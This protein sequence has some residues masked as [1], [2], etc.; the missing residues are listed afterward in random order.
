MR[1]PFYFF[2]AT[3]AR[4]SWGLFLAFLGFA[5]ALTI[6]AQD[7]PY[8]ATVKQ[9]SSAQSHWSFL[10][11]PTLPSDRDVPAAALAAKIDA[12]IDA[13]LDSLDI[14]PNPPASKTAV[15]R[16][17]SFDLTGLPPSDAARASFLG[18]DS[19]DA[20]ERLVDRLLASP[21]FGEHFGRHW[22]DLVRYADTHGLHFDNHRE[23]WMYRDYVIDSF[24]RNKRF[25]VFVIEQLAGDLLQADEP[26]L[27]QEQQIATGFLRMNLTTNEAGS[28]Y[29]EVVAKNLLDLTDAF[30]TVFLGLTTQCAQCHDHKSDPLT[31]RDYYSLAAFFN[32]FDGNAMDNNEKAPPPSIAVPSAE[33]AK[34]MQAWQERISSIDEEIRQPNESIDAAQRAWESRLANDLNALPTKS[35]IEM[36]PWHV[37]GPFDAE[38]I[39]YAY[40]KTFAS[41]GD[42][43]A[44][45]QRFF[46]RDAQL[47]WTPLELSLDGTAAELPGLANRQ[48]VSV[49]HTKIVADKATDIVL[50]LAVEDGVQVFLNDQTVFDQRGIE[51]PFLRFANITLPL[52]EGENTLYLKVVSHAA[53]SRVRIAIAQTWAVPEQLREILA[54]SPEARAEWEVDHLRSYFRGVWG[55]HPDWLAMR[56]ERNGTVRQF[57][58]LLQS[59]PRTLV[60]RESPG[61]AEQRVFQGGRYDQLGDAV[62]P[63]TPAFLP[64]IEHADTPFEQEHAKPFP[65]RLDL[66]QWVTSPENPLTAR[67]AAN[68]FWQALFGLGIVETSEDLGTEGLPP[69]H[70]DLLDLLAAEFASDWDVKRL[71]KAM[72]LSRAYRRDATFSPESRKAD[73]TNRLLARGPRNRLDA[74]QLRDQALTLAGLLNLTAGGLSSKPPQPAGIWESVGHS[75]SNTVTF[76]PDQGDAALRRSV[77][78]FWKRTSPPPSLAV[79]DA[80]TRETCV[81][82]RERTNTPAQALVTMNDPQFF[83]AA[84]RL[85]DMTLA[86]DANEDTNDGVNDGAARMEWLFDRVVGRAMTPRESEELVRLLGDLREHFANIEAGSANRTPDQAAWTLVASTLLNLDEVLCK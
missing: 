71:I 67:A 4:G 57:E 75:Q 37:V 9:S 39:D 16:R 26:K 60:Y 77:Y 69:S 70:A 83:G 48:S 58:A 2:A 25:D 11:L 76:V 34:Q 32:R 45:E 81:T 28:I 19:A 46:Y 84:E 38:T 21:Q 65:D 29:E 78:T 63:A 24:N 6:F 72:V 79:F 40:E 74:E 15:L 33:Q 64:P 54:T 7:R 42:K 3:F 5:P 62:L 47:Q 86:Q 80:P 1:T 22:L 50:Q 55:E 23:V 27:R 52:S 31:Q 53:P 18:D 82:R 49:L 13:R 73:P 43:F 12:Q 8:Q 35:P 56:D 30:G 44:L 41:I 10:P 51:R 20:Y 59:L 66:A 17:I 36:T 68:R 85:A 61:S 14:T